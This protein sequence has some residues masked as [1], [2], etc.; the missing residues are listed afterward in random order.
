MVIGT[1]SYGKG[2]VQTVIRLPNDGELTLTWSRFIAP[3][4]YAIHGLGVS[5]G[6]CTSGAAGDGEELLKTALSGRI[7]IVEKLANWRSVGLQDEER[8]R[9]LRAVC[10]GQRRIGDTE[11]AVARH[12]FDDMPLYSQALDLSSSTTTA[13]TEH[14]SP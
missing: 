12:L 6:I 14:P 5:P 1:T 2:T 11:L 3:S 4:G 10:P 9:D 7:G 8:R 13:S